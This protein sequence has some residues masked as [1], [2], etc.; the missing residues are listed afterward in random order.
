MAKEL[1]LATFLLRYGK[2][3]NCLEAIKDIKYPKG[4]YC[5]KCKA[6]T[7][8]HKVKCR[9][10]YECSCGFQLYPLVGT[11]FQGSKTPLQYWFYAIF[12][13]SVTRSGV[14]AKQL[15]RE[16]GVS[17]K[18]AWRIFM[19]LRSKMADTDRLL[20]GTVE[21]D[22]TFVGGKGYNRGKIWWANWEEHPKE[23]VMGM[24]ERGGR[25]RT[26]H[27]PNT[28]VWTLTKVIKDNIDPKAFV[29]TDNYHGYWNLPMYGYKHDSV[30]HSKHYV[31]GNA[32]VQN[33]ENFWSHFKRGVRG[34]YRHVSPKYLPLY[35]DE[36]GFRYNNRSKQ[37][38]MFKILLGNIV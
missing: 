16:L 22:E 13:M 11:I 20:S 27:I 19:K 38:E 4:I 3:D 2:N 36:Y 29:M 25:V 17:Y 28:G 18:T 33:I 15:Q 6:V 21:V 5:K 34:V 26:K 30:N 10:A 14:S 31:K 1:T 9:Q 32:H 24:V 7:K 35:A 37:S 8:F 23:I 12:V